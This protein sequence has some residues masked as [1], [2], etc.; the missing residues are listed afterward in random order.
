MKKPFL[1]AL[2]A[3]I[4]I[5]FIV[6]IMNLA[7]LLLKSQMGTILIPMTMLSMFVLSAAVMGYLFLS[8]PVSLLVANR[9]K[10]AVVFFAKTVGFFACFGLL[11]AILLFI[12]SNFIGGHIMPD[13]TYMSNDGMTMSQMMADMNK[14]LVGKTGDDFDKAFL[15]EMVVHHQG[16]V[17]MAKLALTNAKHQEIKDLA[18]V[19]ISAQNKEIGSMNSW[20]S[21]WYGIHN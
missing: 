2:G 5:V 17:E 1:H 21:G 13:G 4:F 19:I 6:L 15:A 8:E 20:M 12:K 11:F 3:A 10:E 9:K 16:A 7:N 14:E 18:R